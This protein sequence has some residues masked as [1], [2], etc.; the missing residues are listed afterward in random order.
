MR[1]HG[2][3]ACG[4]LTN[5]M[6]V[7]R[8]WVTGF[9]RFETAHIYI[10]GS[11]FVLPFTNEYG[12]AFEICIVPEISRVLAWKL[13][14]K[15]RS[16][17][18]KYNPKCVQKYHGRTNITLNVKIRSPSQWKQWYVFL[19]KLTSV[20]MH[21]EVEKLR[22]IPQKQN[23]TDLKCR[24]CMHHMIMIICINASVCVRTPNS[25]SQ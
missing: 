14:G 13:E 17:E 16:R 12:C 24:I 11:P 25:I 3:V 23:G 8:D 20:L 21:G 18:S 15:K 7:V 2:F 10:H 19:A 9:C 4:F 5:H 22:W 1:I 6:D